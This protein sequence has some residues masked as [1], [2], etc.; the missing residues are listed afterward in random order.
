MVVTEITTMEV[1]VS[2]WDEIF[3]AMIARKKYLPR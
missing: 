3:H 2:D 1:A